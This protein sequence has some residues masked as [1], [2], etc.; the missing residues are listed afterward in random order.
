MGC[1]DSSCLKVDEKNENVGRRIPLN[2]QMKNKIESKYEKLLKLSD[3]DNDFIKKALSMNNHYRKKHGVNELKLDKDL[4]KRALIL[5]YQK[6]IEGQFSNNYQKNGNNEDLG[7][8]SFESNVKLEAEELIKNWYS[9][10]KEYNPKEPD[11]FQS[12]NSTQMIW[13]N[14]LNF[15]I[16]YYPKALTELNKKAKKEKEKASNEINKYCYV[17]LYHPAGNQPDQYRKNVFNTEQNIKELEAKN[18]NK[19]NEKNDE[20]GKIKFNE[21]LNESNKEK[22]IDNEPENNF[23]VQDYVSDTNAENRKENEENTVNIYKRDKNN[24]S[25]D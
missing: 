18:R 3:L 8:I 21:E 12:L 16:G 22:K 4:S 25:E 19:K 14:S 17:A 11:E 24:N 7:L 20:E 1:S 10:L 15:G 13:K 6:L 5:A 23:E 9:D 2:P